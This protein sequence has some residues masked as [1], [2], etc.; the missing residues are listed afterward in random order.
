MVSFL[1]LSFRRFRV[2]LAI[3]LSFISVYHSL[4]WVLP[5]SAQ[6]MI[7]Q[8]LV[9]LVLLRAS[10]LDQFTRIGWVLAVGQHAA[11]DF[12]SIESLRVSNDHQKVLWPGDGHIQT[13]FVDQE[14]KRPLEGLAVIRPDAVEHNDF[15]LSSLKCIDCVD[16]DS[17]FKSLALLTAYGPH[18]V[19]QSPN[20]RLVRSDDTDLTF[21]GPQ[22]AIF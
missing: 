3:E 21:N 2:N 11:P 6:N 22:A 14:P 16:L 13:S 15:F 10:Y 12:G 9:I 8:S 19:F 17:L 18:L 1:F 4:L 7:F 5:I 20:L